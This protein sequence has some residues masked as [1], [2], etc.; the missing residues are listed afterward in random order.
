MKEILE[1][2]GFTMIKGI[3]MFFG[4]VMLVVAEK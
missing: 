2:A 3:P 1:S 4:S